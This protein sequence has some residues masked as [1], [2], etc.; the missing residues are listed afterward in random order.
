MSKAKRVSAGGRLLDLLRPLLHLP[1]QRVLGGV[2]HVHLDPVEHGVPAQPA[3]ER[4][5]EAPL[6]VGGVARGEVV[7]KGSPNELRE[8]TG[9]D[10]LEDAF[11][12]A[13]GSEEGLE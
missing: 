1:G 9:F 3:R 12:A 5:S 10:N 13:I 4:E 11:V 2:A 6:L 8:S 7:A